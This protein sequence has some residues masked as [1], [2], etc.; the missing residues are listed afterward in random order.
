MKKAR[1]KLILEEL[2]LST[3]GIKN[4]LRDMLQPGKHIL[5]NRNAALKKAPHNS[6]Q[7]TAPQIPSCHTSKPSTQRSH[8]RQ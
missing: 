4:K 7:S 8:L 6:L 3:Q 5:A 1:F 2:S